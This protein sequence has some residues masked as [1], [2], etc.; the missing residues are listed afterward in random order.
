MISNLAYIHPE[1][2]IGNDVTI[3]PFAYIDKNVEIGDGCE[4]MPYV[5]IIA[6]TRM[7][8]NNKVYQGATIGADPQDFRWKGQQT[9][10]YI[11]DDNVLREQ[12]IVNRG[13]NPDGGTRIGN[14]CFINAETHICHDTVIEGNSVLGNGVKIAGDVTLGQCS[15]LSSGVIVNEGCKLG[16]WIFVKGGT[17]ISSNVPP[18]VIMAHN[19]VRYYGIN[20]YIMKRDNA[21]TDAEIEDAAKAYRHIYQTQTSTYNA[22]R[23]I[24]ADIDDNR[25][26]RAI[27][28]FVRNADLHLAGVRFNED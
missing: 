18:F 13:I 1:A 4:I 21:F 5:S 11:G 15:I 16:S 22:L 8:R 6:G 14:N 24:E 26:R 23:R 2:R 17:R 28:D 9:Y 19:P 25:I 20:S 3:H 27:L 7:G 12:V 10:C